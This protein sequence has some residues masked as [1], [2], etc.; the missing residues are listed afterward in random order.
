M[1]Q[2]QRVGLHQLRLG[3]SH[4]VFGQ[5]GHDLVTRGGNELLRC[6]VLV[7]KQLLFQAIGW[8]LRPVGDPGLVLAHQAGHLLLRF[9]HRHGAL[10]RLR[11]HQP[12]LNQVHGRRQDV[13]HHVL[14]HKG[15]VGDGVEAVKAHVGLQGN[16]Q[17]GQDT[18]GGQEKGRTADRSEHG[19]P[20]NGSELQMAICEVRA[21]KHAI[22]RTQIVS[23]ISYEVQLIPGRAA[24]LL[25][26]P[27][28]DPAL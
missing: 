28:L 4:I 2:V 15:L 20:L 9:G 5:G 12:Q 17:G 14:G 6:L 19:A 8:V 11:Q 26:N 13:G 27:C 16:H 1:L 21:C 24:R 3:R 18:H 22:S 23:N 25:V 7:A 10:Y